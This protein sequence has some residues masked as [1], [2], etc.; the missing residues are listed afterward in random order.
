MFTYL[1]TYD[2]R[3]AARRAGS[4]ATAESCREQTKDEL[5]RCDIPSLGRSRSK[6]HRLGKQSDQCDHGV[7]MHG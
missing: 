2:G 1:L 4:S 6:R 5:T 7:T 3:D